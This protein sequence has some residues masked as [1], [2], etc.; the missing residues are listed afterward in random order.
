MKIWFYPKKDFLS[1]YRG[2]FQKGKLVVLVNESTAS[3][4][5]I[6]SGAVQDW[7]RGAIV[8]R[9]TF[10]KGLVQRPIPLTDGSKVRI[11]TQRY[12]TPSGRCIQKSYEDG[13]KA[14]RKEKYER[15]LNGESFSKDSI[16]IP[17]SL[18]FK[19]L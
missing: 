2:M 1:T 7:D 13:T 11:T 9:R 5:E 6:V 15:Y 8:G 17:Y 14:Y 10:G 18:V 3:A 4:S 12:Y 19:T 16:N